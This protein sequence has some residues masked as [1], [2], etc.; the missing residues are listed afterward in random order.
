VAFGNQGD[1]RTVTDGA[2]K[3]SFDL[4]SD[5]ARLFDLAADPGERTDLAAKRPEETRRLEAVLLRWMKAQEGPAGSRLSHRRA[6]ELEKQL[7]A[8]GYL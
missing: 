1:T 6:H 4:I 5:T 7:H 2:W 8:V 3:L